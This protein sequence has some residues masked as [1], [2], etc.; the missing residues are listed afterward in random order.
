MFLSRFLQRIP[1]QIVREVVDKGPV[2]CFTNGASTGS[3]ALEE[4][5]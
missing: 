4:Y 2:A 1:L 5:P 3:A